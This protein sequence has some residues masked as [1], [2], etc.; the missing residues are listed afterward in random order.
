MRKI[1]QKPLGKTT[2]TQAG[3]ALIVLHKFM[4]KKT[5]KFTHFVRKGHANEFF[6]HSAL[7]DM[8][9]KKK[10]TRKVLR[11]RHHRAL[12]S[13]SVFKLCFSIDL[14]LSGVE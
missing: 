13:I 8:V 6:I 3:R 2:I 7:Q 9:T 4:R 14:R 5:Y 12:T 10:A 11:L 1:Y